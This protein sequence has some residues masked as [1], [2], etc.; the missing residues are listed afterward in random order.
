MRVFR[1]SKFQRHLVI[2]LMLICFMAA[3]H[4]W[5]PVDSPLEWTL[6]DHH[7]KVRLTLEAG[8]RIEVD[9]IYVA[10]DSVFWRA[11]DDVGLGAMRSG[12]SAPLSDVAKAEV[13]KTDVVGTLGL[14]VGVTVAAS[15]VLFAV[16]A[17]TCN[18]AAFFCS[19]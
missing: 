1:R 8:H 12:F 6:A 3:C 15:V 18:P 16:Y 4:K 11:H 10:R 5:V 7:G 13:R 17:A 14:V 2:P 19:R 9:S